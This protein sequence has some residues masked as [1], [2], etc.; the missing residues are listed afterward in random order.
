MRGDEG[1]PRERC[2]ARR[3]DRHVVEVQGLA[4]LLPE[5]LI[6]ELPVSDR[7]VVRVGK[8]RAA[9]REIVGEQQRPDHHRIKR[10]VRVPGAV[11]HGE[12]VEAELVAPR[13][14]V[15][16]RRQR[17]EPRVAHVGRHAPRLRHRGER[18]VDRRGQTVAQGE[19][20]QARCLCRG[21]V[22]GRC[23]SRSD[24]LMPRLIEP[25]HVALRRVGQTRDGVVGDHVDDAMPVDGAVEEGRARC[26]SSRADP[27][28]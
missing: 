11:R 26:R 4:E 6:A 3:G 25:H 16:V 10:H 24:A 15:H 19:V 1:G 23:R 8:G 5:R 12:H 28:T 21:T 17:R 9:G 27:R 22:Q 7:P 14:R 13:G 2:G 20:R 18:H